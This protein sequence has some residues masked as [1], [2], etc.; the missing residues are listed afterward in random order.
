MIFRFSYFSWCN[1]SS[2][3]S[4]TIENNWPT[5][6]FQWGYSS[7][8]TKVFCRGWM[9]FVQLVCTR[10]LPAAFFQNS[11][12]V[13]EHSMKVTKKLRGFFALEC[14]HGNREREEIKDRMWKNTECPRKENNGIMGKER[15]RIK[16]GRGEVRREP[17][18]I[19]RREFGCCNLPHIA[20]LSCRTSSAGST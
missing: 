3:P 1:E 8:K 7:I 19:V 15:K 14:S 18:A 9:L 20:Q 17:C 12:W 4:K 5:K 11:F 10:I 2:S 13:S 16:S 6:L